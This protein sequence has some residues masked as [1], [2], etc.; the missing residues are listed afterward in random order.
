MSG[1]RELEDVVTEDD[2]SKSLWAGAGGKWRDVAEATLENGYLPPVF[3]DYLDLSLGGTLAVGGIE[4]QS[5]FQG[6]QLDHVLELEVAILGQDEPVLCSPTMNKELFNAVRGG[7]G[8]F[9]IIA[10]VK[11]PL[12]PAPTYVCYNRYLYESLQDLIDDMYQL[13]DNGEV[14]GVQGQA[15]PSESDALAQATG[16]R[17]LTPLPSQFPWLIRLSFMPRPPTAPTLMRTS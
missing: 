7:L 15:V 16:V 4:S 8:Q 10:R 17:F 12:H 6:V 9:G 13:V 1:V 5:P 14:A 11:L 3:T 2:G